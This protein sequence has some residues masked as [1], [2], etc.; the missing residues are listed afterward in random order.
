MEDEVGRKTGRRRH[1]D[2]PVAVRD[3]NEIVGRE[4]LDESLPQLPPGA[5]D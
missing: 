1:A 3:G 5:G 2:V 4:G